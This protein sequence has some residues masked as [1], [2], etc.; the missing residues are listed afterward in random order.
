MQYHRE[1]T[2]S[3]YVSQ[4][5]RTQ[6]DPIDNLFNALTYFAIPKSYLE[7]NV[8]FYLL[9]KDEADKSHFRN[10]EQFCSKVK[11]FKRSNMTNK[12]ILEKI[13]IFFSLPGIDHGYLSIQ[14][15]RVH[16]WAIPPCPMSPSKTDRLLCDFL[17]FLFSV[18]VTVTKPLTSFV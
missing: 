2:K 13:Y 14:V 1:Q 6:P 17:L 18:S 4:W 8:A 16:H 7:R 9:I 15:E 3:V 5:M 11:V 12:W 10:I